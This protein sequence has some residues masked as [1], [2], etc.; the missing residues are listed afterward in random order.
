MQGSVG[1]RQ[2]APGRDTFHLG[3]NVRGVAV[4]GKRGI[5]NTGRAGLGQQER[6][7]GTAASETHRGQGT[8]AGTRRNAGRHME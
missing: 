6:E 3:D 1:A 7:R 4:T 8:G 2:R 5:N